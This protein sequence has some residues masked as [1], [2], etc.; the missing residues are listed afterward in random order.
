MVL[1]TRC[2]EIS[3]IFINL[4]YNKLI[5]KLPTFVMHLFISLLLSKMCCFRVCF[6]KT[7]KDVCSIVLSNGSHTLRTFHF[8]GMGTFLGICG[9]QGQ[10]SPVSLQPHT[11]PPA[12]G[13]VERA[14]GLRMRLG[15]ERATPSQSEAR[16]ANDR[17]SLAHEAT[18]CG[19]PPI[20]LCLPPVE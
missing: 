17:H 1:T 4:F 9:G 8:G 3:Y 10:L 20:S 7:A 16:H 14:R 13:L 2:R 18:E 11:P 19:L 12:D 15:E 5:N 6:C